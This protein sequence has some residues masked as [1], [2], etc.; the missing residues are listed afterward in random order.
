MPADD[1]FPSTMQ[2][3]AGLDIKPALAEADEPPRPVGIRGLSLECFQ[4]VIQDAIEYDDQSDSNLRD[5]LSLR[6]VSKLFEVEVM[7]AIYTTKLLRKMR[8]NPEVATLRQRG[9]ARMVTQHCRIQPCGDMSF[10]LARYLMLQ[11]HGTLPWNA[12]LSTLINAVVDR[13]MKDDG[14]DSDGAKRL[15]YTHI[16]CQRAVHLPSPARHYGSWHLFEEYFQ[17]LLFPA[18]SAITME[19]FET[20]VLSAK[21]YIKHPDAEKLVL[22]RLFQ[23]GPK[24]LSTFKKSN[25]R[26]DDEGENHNGPVFGSLLE[27]SLRS[28]NPDLTARLM[29]YE[30]DVSRERSTVDS[31]GKTRR[32]KKYYDEYFW[33]LALAYQDLEA[34]KAFLEMTTREMTP[35]KLFEILLEAV[36]TSQ[37]E[38]LRILLRHQLPPLNE[39]SESARH[40]KR[41]LRIQIIELCL[42]EAIRHGESQALGVLLRSPYAVESTYFTHR[43]KE[44]WG[45]MDHGPETFDDVPA[46]DAPRDRGPTRRR[47]DW[48]G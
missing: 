34:L 44:Y 25:T 35:K 1:M 4:L 14:H 23:R 48:S 36:C 28:E 6:Q 24:S 27:A 3:L 7:R 26:P 41:Q 21:V 46:G 10:F 15:Q 38:A 43:W 11:P 9:H 13:L 18:Q 22:D 17:S 2:A 16:L 19:T 42:E 39:G 30:V 5:A 32:G 45:H 31:K 40:E 8:D 29:N 47:N 33:R 37:A 20:V 12:N